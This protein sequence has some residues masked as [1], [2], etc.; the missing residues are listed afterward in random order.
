MYIYFFSVDAALTMDVI[1]QVVLVGAG[2]RMPKVQDLLAEYVGSELSKNLNA[3]E[4]AVLG[5]VYKAADLSQGFKVKKYITKDSV[6]FPIQIVF[7]K[8]TEDKSKQVRI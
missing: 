6:L 3:D 5:A 1:S 7:D 2:T 4:A 8:S